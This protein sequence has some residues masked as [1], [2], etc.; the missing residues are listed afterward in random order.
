ML[1]HIKTLCEE[2]SNELGIKPTK[3]QIELGELTQLRNATKINDPDRPGL[4]CIGSRPGMGKTTFALDI[5]L[6]AAISNQK[7]ILIFS[8]E[9]TA[10]QNA[11]R[12]LQK[13]SGVNIRTFRDSTRSEEDKA[14][15]SSAIAFLQEQNILID[16]SFST[17]PAYIEKCLQSC[18]NPIVVLIDYLQ[19]VQADEECESRQRE[20]CE[21]TRSLLV[22]ARKYCVKIV[23]LTQIGRIFR[24]DKR[25]ILDDVRSIGCLH[26]DSDVVLLVYRDEYY[27]NDSAN[28]AA[29]IIIAKNRYGECCTIHMRFDGNTVSFKEDV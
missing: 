24:E 21:I 29:E 14:K 2:I 13:L 7:D 20:L 4:I 22:Q 9:M 27:E 6:D 16:D 10:K 12:L 19:L 1:I 3:K 5:V 23:V 8:L 25:P 26:Q 17:S 11:E 18:E 15:L 28:D